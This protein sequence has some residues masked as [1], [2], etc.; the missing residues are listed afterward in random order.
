MLKHIQMGVPN[1]LG[2]ASGKDPIFDI[3]LIF[4][5]VYKQSIII[6]SI[7]AHAI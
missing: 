3:L 2:G 5:Q 1:L 6:V 7:T 4:Q